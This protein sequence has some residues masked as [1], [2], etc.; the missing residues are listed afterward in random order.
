MKNKLCVCFSPPHKARHA[1]GSA[2]PVIFPFPTYC[3]RIHGN[4]TAEIDC[5]F[6]THLAESELHFSAKEELINSVHFKGNLKSGVKMLQCQ[7]AVL[8]LL[9]V[10][11]GGVAEGLASNCGG[12]CENMLLISGFESKVLKT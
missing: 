10:D 11:S 1:A 6:L 5:A 2:L 7:G 12:I 9:Q 8:A 4:R 3:N